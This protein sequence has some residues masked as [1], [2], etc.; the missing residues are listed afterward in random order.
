MMRKGVAI[1]AISP[2]SV[3]AHAAFRERHTIR[4]PLL[5]DERTAEG[6]P[7]TCELYGVWQAKRL[8]GTTSMGVV[9][10]TSIIDPAG[11]VSHRFDAVRVRGHIDAVLHALGLPAPR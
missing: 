6:T 4:F 7:K 8:Y 11:I 9:R 3:R 2:D 5:V 10:T 1:L